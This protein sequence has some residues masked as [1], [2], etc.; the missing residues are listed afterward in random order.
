MEGL[1]EDTQHLLA[2]RDHQKTLSITERVEVLESSG[3]DVCRFDIGE[4]GHRLAETRRDLVHR[5]KTG[6]A[7]LDADLR[8]EVHE[9]HHHRECA[10]DLANGSD[11]FPVH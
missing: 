10:T 6:L 2:A 4:S 5:R 7:V 9:R 8:R 1:L 11:R 3:E